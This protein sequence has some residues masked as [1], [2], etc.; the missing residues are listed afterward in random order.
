[1]TL[2]PRKEPVAQAAPTLNS[3]FPQP[4]L[5]IALV[6]AITSVQAAVARGDG[7]AATGSMAYSR[8][9]HT[10]TLLPDGRVLVARRGSDG[11]DLNTAELYYPTN[12]IWTNTGK[13]ST[14]RFAHTATLLH[15]GKVLVAW[16]C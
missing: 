10:S 4:R 14:P 8:Y 13:F 6:L 1:M 12:G 11:P 16:A 15:N 9:Y 3:I 2:K 5:H 7:F